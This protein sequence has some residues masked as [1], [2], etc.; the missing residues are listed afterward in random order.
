[1]ENPAL[2]F[3]AD[4]YEQKTVD[5]LIDVYK[6]KGYAVLPNVFKRETVDPFVDRLKEAVYHN[7]IEYMIPDDS[8]LHVWASQAPRVRQILTPAL[9]H[10]VAAPPISMCNTMWIVTSHD[11][12]DTVPTWHKDREPDGMPGKEYHY[13]NDVFVGF[14]FEDVTDETGPLEVIPGS[15]W[16]AT[17]TP[18]TDHPHEKIYLNKEDGLLLDQRIWHQGTPRS[19]PGLRF[20][21]VYAYYLVPIHYG[22]AHVMP[23][24]QRELWMKQTKRNEQAFWGGVFQP[25]Q[26]G[27]E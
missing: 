19:I 14:Y 18:Y 25:P 6:Q 16:D 26:T 5:S 27:S 7:G 1:M 17:V 13:A 15:H 10:T 21:V 3:V 20:L 24:I 4:P 23:R 12:P 8:L 22:R 9:T 11:Q 2:E